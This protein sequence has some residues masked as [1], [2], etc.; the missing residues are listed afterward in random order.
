MYSARAWQTAETGVKKVSNS[1]L[2]DYVGTTKNCSPRNHTIDTITIHCTA[3]QSCVEAIGAVLEEKGASCNYAIGFDGKVGI[4]A[5]ENM[6]SYCSS[7]GINDHR[8]ITIEVASDMYEPCNVNAVVYDKLIKLLVDICQRN[9]IPRLLWRAD[10]SLIG[11]IDKQNMTVHRWFNPNKSCPGEYLYSR[12]GQ[13]A[14]EVNK[15]LAQPLYRVQ[16]GAF[17]DKEN[18]ENFL[19][20]VKKAGFENAFIVTVYT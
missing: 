12:M 9:N 7:N 11:Q 15:Q 13:I 1:A 14:D 10:K 17:R 6:R 16:V 4:F 2:I 20:T 3:G 19:E 18:A 8:A 5:A